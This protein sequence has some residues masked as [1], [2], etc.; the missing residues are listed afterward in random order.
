[1]KKRSDISMLIKKGQRWKCPSFV[2]I[3]S[4]NNLSY[5]RFAVLV[6]RRIGIAVK[7][8]KI[9]RIFRELFRTNKIDT[10]PFFD[11]LIQPRPGIEDKYSKL[12]TDCYKEW[13]QRVKK[14]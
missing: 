14:Y 11:I 2:I 13:H 8:N 5:D 7:R 3:Y 1:M 9:K 12:L 6:S 10:P 4:E